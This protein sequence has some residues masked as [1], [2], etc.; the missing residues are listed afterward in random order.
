MAFVIHSAVRDVSVFLA[1][2]E[3]GAYDYLQIPFTREILLAV[4]H[5]ALEHRTLIV[6]NRGYQ[7]NLESLVAD[8]TEN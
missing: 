1:A 8:R 5:R 3:K 4:V 7:A 6:E 2:L